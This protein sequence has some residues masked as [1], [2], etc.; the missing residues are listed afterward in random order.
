L[1]DNDE[2]FERETRIVRT[3]ASAAGTYMVLSSAVLLALVALKPEQIGA[4]S[5]CWFLICIVSAGLYRYFG[6]RYLENLGTRYDLMPIVKRS[7]WLNA[8]ANKPIVFYVGAM[9]AFYLGWLGLLWN[10]L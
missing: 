7:R 8:W 9:L 4:L 2:R 5:A 10:L 3:Y 1:S 6:L